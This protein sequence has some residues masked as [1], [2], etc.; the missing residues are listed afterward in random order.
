LGV[1]LLSIIGNEQIVLCI[2]FGALGST[3]HDLC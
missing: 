2:G 1:Y 3:V